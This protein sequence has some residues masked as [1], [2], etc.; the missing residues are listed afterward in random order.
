M[1]LCERAIIDKFSSTVESPKTVQ[2]TT[3]EVETGKEK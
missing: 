2:E 3:K 1:N